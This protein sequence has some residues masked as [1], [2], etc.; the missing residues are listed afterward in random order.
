MSG[1][2]LPLFLP[3]YLC[4]SESHPVRMYVQQRYV[5]SDWGLPRHGHTVSQP[6]NSHPRRRRAPVRSV[7][8]S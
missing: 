3:L 2:V 1:S 5:A 7:A 4:F 6:P 8:R